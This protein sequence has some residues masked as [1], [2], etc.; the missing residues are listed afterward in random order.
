MSIEETS[1]ISEIRLG[2]LG[3]VWLGL[4]SLDWPF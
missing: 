3:E 1:D 2:S 4:D